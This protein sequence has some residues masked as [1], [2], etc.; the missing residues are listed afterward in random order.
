MDTDDPLKQP[1]KIEGPDRII[2]CITTCGASQFMNAPPAPLRMPSLALPAGFHPN[3]RNMKGERLPAT[4]QFGF[5]QEVLMT[6]ID[7]NQII[8]L[9]YQEGHVAASSISLV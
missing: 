8:V 3:L 9:I 4:R 5:V 6:D 1:I 2:Q 7:G